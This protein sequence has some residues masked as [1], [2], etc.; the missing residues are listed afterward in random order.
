LRLDKD[1]ATINT[2]WRE[3]K[4]LESSAPWINYG[5]SEEIS[6]CRMVVLDCSLFLIKFEEILL[7]INKLSKKTKWKTTFNY[8]L[9]N[10]FPI[11]NIALSVII[12]VM[13]YLF[14]GR[15]KAES[16]LSHAKLNKV[17]TEIAEID[18]SKKEIKDHIDITIGNLKIKE[19]TQQTVLNDL[20]EKIL[21][22]ESSFKDQ[23]TR[24]EIDN[25]NLSIQLKNIE[26]DVSE[27]KSK[28]DVSSKKVN[29]TSEL[30]KMLDEIQPK[31]SVMSVSDQTKYDEN[32]M[33]LILLYTL[34]NKG[35]YSIKVK[36]PNCLLSNAE[37]LSS[38]NFIE[39]ESLEH[40]KDFSLR[41]LGFTGDLYPGETREIKFY[42]YFNEKPYSG[43]GISKI[44]KTKFYAETPD[45][46][47]DA[48]KPFIKGV[49]SNEKLKEM[50]KTSI[51]Y[52]NNISFNIRN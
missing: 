45:S 33:E 30:T 10:L 15:F 46:V 27:L 43:A 14:I 32:K 37:I 23:R 20:T 22:I 50:A 47:L 35:K 31:L 13:G 51:N 4:N 1:V 29:I 9:D 52:S 8:C 11:I 16:D 44:F 3:G 28:L 12:A 6:L 42:I 38:N 17:S 48:I 5:T 18:L 41:I 19:S 49:I 40:G 2:F 36:D 26:K 39:K 21:S 24:L 7:M 25:L 34:S